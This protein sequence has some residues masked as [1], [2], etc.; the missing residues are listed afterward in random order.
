MKIL[1]FG[2]SLVEQDN[3]A[4][5]LIPK[6]KQEFPNI[7]FIEADPTEE[8]QN[9]GKDLTMIDIA[10]GI[11]EV[12]ILELKTLDDFSKLQINKIYTMHDF[13]LGYNLRLLKK[14]N[15]IKTVKIICIPFKGDEKEIFNGLKKTLNT[16]MN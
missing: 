2:N 9:Y 13:D 3:L 11:D 16:L 14:L 12:K 15:L 1:I 6:L 4:I 8:L 5:R 7:Q 10:E